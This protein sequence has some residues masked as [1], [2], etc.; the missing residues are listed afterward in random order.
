MAR[1]FWVLQFDEPDG[2]PGRGVARIDGALTD[3][4]PVQVSATIRSFCSTVH[5][6]R[7]PLP[8]KISSRLTG[9]DIDVSYLCV[10]HKSNSA[11][12]QMDGRQHRPPRRPLPRQAHRPDAVEG[13]S[14]PGRRRL[15]VHCRV[16]G[17]LPNAQPPLLC[18][19][20]RRQFN[21]IV[22]QCN[23]TAISCMITIVVITGSRGGSSRKASLKELTNK[24]R[25]ATMISFRR[26]VW[27][28]H[29]RIRTA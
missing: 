22:E 21:G 17:R 19:A 3:S 5:D 10:Q 6:R 1:W 8:V 4:P 13:R 12:C 16:R 24:A 23:S 14:H 20:K 28:D 7:R 2:W 29:A 15:R 25:F 26:P 27:G 11:R 18:L 9:S